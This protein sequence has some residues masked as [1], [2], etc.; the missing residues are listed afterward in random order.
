MH[1]SLEVDHDGTPDLFLIGDSG[2]KING[3]DTPRSQIFAELA[4]CGVPAERP[5][6][7]R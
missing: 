5:G 6:R 3:K 2:A 7:R 4:K 1:V